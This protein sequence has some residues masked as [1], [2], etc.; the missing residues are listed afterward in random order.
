MI[1]GGGPAGAILGAYLARAGVDHAILDKAV[2]PRPARRRVAAL[3]DDARLPGDR[4][5]RTRRA[6]AASCAST[7]RSGPTTPTPAASRCRSSRSR[8]SASSSPGAGTSTASR[9][10]DA[11]LRHAARAGLARARGRAGRA[12]RARRARAAR[13]G[14]V[15]ARGRRRARLLRARLVVD[16][17]GRGT[18][19]GSQLRMKR[20]DP[21]FRQFAV[22]GWFE[23]VDRG[24]A[25]TAEWIHVHVLPGPRA[26]AWQIP[27]SEGVTSVGVV[28]DADA[29]PEG[30]RGPRPRSS[31]RRSRRARRS[32]ARM[33]G[34]RPLHALQRE[35]NYSYA[36]ERLAGDG[37][38]LVGDAARFVDPLFSSG[39]SVAAESA[40]EAA[41]G[42]PRRA[43]RAA[44]SRPPPSRRYERRLRG[45]LD[46]WRE[47]IGLYYRCRARSSRCSPTPPSASSS[48]T[49]CRATS[50]RAGRR[51]GVER[52]RA[53]IARV[54]AD[55]SIRV[56]R[57][58][59]HC[60]TPAAQLAALRWPRRTRWVSSVRS[61]TLL[62]SA[63]ALGSAQAAATLRGG[64]GERRVAER[65]GLARERRRRASRSARASPSALRVL[66]RVDALAEPDH[67]AVDALVE[68]G[69]LGI[70]WTRWASAGLHP[71]AIGAPRDPVEAPRLLRRRRRGC[72]AASARARR[73]RGATARP[74]GASR[75]GA[76]SASASGAPGARR[77]EVRGARRLRA[78][79]APR[80]GRAARR[81]R[82]RA[83]A[84]RRAEST[85][86][87]GPAAP[88]RRGAPRARAL[89]ER[90]RRPARGRA[91]R[92][93]PPPRSARA[94][95]RRAR[96]GA[97]SAKLAPAAT[98][99]P[100]SVGVSSARAELG[101]ER[102]DAPRSFGARR[103]ASPRPR[104]VGSAGRPRRDRAAER[105]RR[106][107]RA[108]AGAAATPRQSARRRR[109]ARPRARVGGE[110]ARA[111]AR[112][113]RGQ[114]ALELREP[115]RRSAS[116]RRARAAR[117]VRSR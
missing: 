83:R 104:A 74:S 8:A 107:A 44:T 78:R 6:R 35:G 22:H 76:R 101:G 47:F 108:R 100:G 90:A 25:A 81:A 2:H 109:C 20:N 52:L 49:C 79:R 28:C 103:R 56:R 23:G 97:P 70:A 84:A 12:R 1:V 18:L 112:L 106:G 9:F 5:P 85:A 41:V 113:R 105:R 48:A 111:V 95:A 71:G 72:R 27:I 58:A 31:P 68:L 42:D 96:R 11:L 30:R 14:V 67:E 117:G 87:V 51:S 15:R 60:V 94:P 93:A 89:E 34:A 59:W 88:R 82:A 62:R 32:R 3:R 114:L 16:A 102:L 66:E 39:L 26:W 77:P 24:A 80:G 40:R 17:T 36:M 54:E 86:S 4:L 45:G 29:L 46:A 38:L 91:A 7:A 73:A 21:G 110:E 69:I 64:V 33:A 98:S 50:T 116:S 63:S 55:P 13:I 19:L 65:V 75:A 99:A 43:R 92:G 61:T 53:E 10:D 37:W 57:P 115:P